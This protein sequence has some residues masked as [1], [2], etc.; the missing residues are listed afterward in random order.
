MPVQVTVQVQMQVALLPMQVPV[1]VPIQV[2]TLVSTRLRMSV[3]VKVAA[4]ACLHEQKA[5]S[6]PPSAKTVVSTITLCRFVE[7]AQL[8]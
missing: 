6:E 7:E 2:S 3:Q 5:N 8:P 4:I 1:Q